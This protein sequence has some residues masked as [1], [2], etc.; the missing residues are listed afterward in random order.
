MKSNG[1]IAA[2]LILPI[3]VLAL[4][5]AAAAQTRIYK[6]MNRS[7]QTDFVNEQ[8]RNLTRQLSGS[9]YELTPEFVLEIQKAVDYYS[10]RI[11]NNAGDVL[12]K[13]DARFIFERGQ[14]AAP[15]LIRAFKAHNLSPLFG[16]YIP[17]IE[18]E[19]MN[20]QT[21]NRA[22]STGMFQFIPPTG[23]RFGLST[24]DLTDVDK[25]ADA[26]ARY[27]SG[28]ISKFNASSTKEALALLSYNRGEGAVERDLATVIKDDNR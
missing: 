21:P 5:T 3:I 18:S 11:D 17:L 8:A 27:I 10:S 1:R 15:T 28:L 22:G 13:G 6:Q 9:E 23:Q 19:F 26:A 16:L 14:V 25:S 7:G 20:I 4:G 2:A 24:A 12:G